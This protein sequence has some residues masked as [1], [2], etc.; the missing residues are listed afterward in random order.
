M[1]T[2]ARIR[3]LWL[4]RRDLG[5]TVERATAALPQTALQGI[6]IVTSGR[7]ML[8]SLVG[9]VTTVVGG[10]ANVTRYTV[11]PAGPL[12]EQNL[13][14]AI[15]DINALAVGSFMGLTGVPTDAM[16]TGL[17][18]IPGMTMSL[19]IWPGTINIRCAGS[20]GGGGRVKYTLKYTPYDNQASVAAV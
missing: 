1:R 2:S 15:T 12:A 7:I 6:F 5:Q 14:A 20:D 10:V 3:D 9:E 17:G 8:N 4:G 11:I 19:L 16:L 13:C 18:V